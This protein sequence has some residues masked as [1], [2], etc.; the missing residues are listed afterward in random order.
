MRGL[1]PDDRRKGAIMLIQANRQDCGVDRPP[2]PLGRDGNENLAGAVNGL[3][4]DFFRR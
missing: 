2:A 3:L 1:I 4:G